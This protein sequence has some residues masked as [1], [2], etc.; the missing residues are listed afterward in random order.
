MFRKNSTQSNSNNTPNPEVKGEQQVS[1]PDS[2]LIVTG[3]NPLSRPSSRQS[4]VSEGE[5]SVLPDGSQS[6]TRMRT[7]S[8]NFL[9]RPMSAGSRTRTESQES[10]ESEEGLVGEVDQNNVAAQVRKIV[11]TA[12]PIPH[13]VGH[14]SAHYHTGLSAALG[15]LVVYYRDQYTEEQVISQD[16]AEESVE[17]T[18]VE[19]QIAVFG[20]E[21]SRLVSRLHGMGFSEASVS[22]RSGTRIVLEIQTFVPPVR[23]IEINNALQGVYTSI[24]QKAEQAVVGQWRSEHVGGSLPI[25]LENRPIAIPD[26]A[27]VNELQP[28]AEAMEAAVSQSLTGLLEVPVRAR[29]LLGNRVDQFQLRVSTALRPHETKILGVLGRAD[30]KVKDMGKPGQFIIQGSY[31]QIQELYQNYDQE[32]KGSEDT[33]EE[34]GTAESAVQCIRQIIQRELPSV[35]ENERPQVS[36][37]EVGRSTRVCITLPEELS[38]SPAQK[39]EIEN[40]FCGKFG[41]RKEETGATNQVAM[42]ADYPIQFSDKLKYDVLNALKGQVPAQLTQEEKQTLDRINRLA[43]EVRIKS[44]AMES[45]IEKSTLKEAIEAAKEAL[46]AT[47]ILIGVAPS[48]KDKVE[49]EK[50]LSRAAELS[51]LQQMETAQQKTLDDLIGQIIDPKE[52]VELKNAITA[53]DDAKDKLLQAKQNRIH[54]I[55]RARN[56]VT[57][58][59]TESSFHCVQIRFVPAVLEAQAQDTLVET[60]EFLALAHKENVIAHLRAHGVAASS[61]ESNGKAKLPIIEVTQ[62]VEEG[63]KRVA[64]LPVAGVIESKQADDTKQE[65]VAANNLDSAAQ[66]AA[67]VRKQRLTFSQAKKQQQAAKNLSR[68]SSQGRL[69]S[70]RPQSSS[71]YSSE[72]RS[73]LLSEV[74]PENAVVVVDENNVDATLGAASLNPA[75]VCSVSY[76]LQF[77]DLHVAASNGLEPAL[78]LSLS[79]EQL[80]S[81]SLSAASETKSPEVG[82]SLKKTRSVFGSMRNLLLGNHGNAQAGSGTPENNSPVSQQPKS[83]K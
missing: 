33:A 30:F 48:E 67:P 66:A 8:T 2:D 21:S 60:E 43:E 78:S 28:T 81:S 65:V 74:V 46:R 69:S 50:V 53:H 18:K 79:S 82:G 3:S 5:P 55:E 57:V 62:T 54:A 68:T 75:Q 83:G 1:I 40:Y 23:P 49:A 27:K 9:G 47:R 24:A 25:Q 52:Q 63:Y 7:W 42:Y 51:R 36:L 34:K 17:V 77:P 11:E 14:N 15:S 31:E 44:I 73:S 59:T 4:I 10:T 80:N 71:K 32:V 16:G 64:A 76:T 39:G 37:R 70:G 26:V 20:Q 22:S 58:E 12:Q 41:W 6:R 61:P 72:H 45:K 19:H 29:L 35:P 38:V 13:N 56:L